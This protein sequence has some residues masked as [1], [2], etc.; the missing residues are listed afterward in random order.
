M[1]VSGVYFQHLIGGPVANVDVASCL[2]FDGID[3]E[4]LFGD[5]LSWI[6]EWFS[7]LNIRLV[8][9]SAKRLG[10]EKSR[11][12]SIK[13]LRT[14]SD[15]NIMP[16]GFNSLTF[17]PNS[18]NSIKDVWTPDAY[19]SIQSGPTF[20]LAFA[21]IS[22]ALTPGQFKEAITEADRLFRPCATYGFYFPVQLSAPGYFHAIVFDPRSREIAGYTRNCALRLT[23][24]RDNALIGIKKAEQRVFFGPCDGYIRDVYPF[25]SVNNR[26]LDR[27]LDGYSLREKIQSL[28]IGELDNNEN[29]NFWSIPADS[30]ASAQSILDSFGVTLS[31]SI[32]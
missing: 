12:V 32:K 28:S 29:R 6:E 26:F 13:N 22:L 21:S 27:K 3:S 14:F 23:N 30:L 19:F 9:A 17:Y 5:I 18:K 24:W 15:A 8:R 10:E 4:V 25:M 2:Y 11:S 1:N 7:I 20:Y 31:S 16:E